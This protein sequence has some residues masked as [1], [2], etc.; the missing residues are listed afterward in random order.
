MLLK[1]A[2]QDFIEDREFKNLTQKTISGYSATLKEFQEFISEQEVVNANDVTQSHIKSYL[3]HCKKNKNNNPTSINHKLHNLKIFF[4]YLQDIEV[5]SEKQNPAK[6]INYVKEDIKIE[7]FNDYQIKQM[8]DYYR[9]I[10]RREKGFYAYRNY[11]II[12]FLLG[13]GSRLGELI[14]LR[15]DDIDFINNTIVF[16]G[17][18]REYSSIPMTEKLKKELMEYKTY[19]EQ[20]FE[21]LSEY[22]FTNRK[23]EKLTDNAV[24]CIFKRLKKVMNFKNVRV[25]C[26]TFRHTFAVNMIKNNCDIF[27]L[28]KMLRHKDLS[29]CRRYVNFGTALKEQNDKFNPLNEIVFRIRK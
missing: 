8:L 24:K 28:Q 26:H 19:C 29:M 9:R 20:T 25:S 12:V 7:V 4:N 14:N 27:T 6:K 10:K 2:I 13:T 15:W 5:I 1:F 22:V 3:L 17:K 23:N 18:K 21:S 11:T 16:Y